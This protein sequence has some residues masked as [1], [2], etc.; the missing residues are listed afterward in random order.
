MLLGI[1]KLHELVQKEK[2][3]ENLC[4]RE[5]NN[6]EGS[7]F[8]LRLAEIYK[9]DEAGDNYFLGVEARNT[10]DIKLVAKNDGSKSEDE[11]S[12]IFE[13]G[14]YYLIKTKK[15]LFT[16]PLGLFLVVYQK[17]APKISM[18]TILRI[19]HGRK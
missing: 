4:E 8:D 16:I 13:P 11:N 6:P 7:G 10:P 2:L 12:F 18:N 3:V 19:I 9:L 17:T 14:K 15:E 5:L 1:K